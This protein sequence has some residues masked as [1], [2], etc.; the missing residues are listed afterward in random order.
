MIRHLTLLVLALLLSAC[1]DR[2]LPV[3]GAEALLYPELHSIKID[4]KRNGQKAT[5]NKVREVITDYFPAAPD[6]E[7]V[8]LY[9]PK[10]QSIA[11]KAQQQL[12]DA[13]VSPKQIKR[14]A[15]PSLGNDI[16]I[17]IK[18]YQLITEDCPTYQFG[19]SR[20]KSSCFIDTLRMKHI[21]APSRLAAKP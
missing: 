12:I 4:V 17:T 15:S 7:W 1:A 13:G 8:I 2:P 16:V 10:Q 6:T 5:Q 14:T 21:A 3:K 18:Q 20:Q 19:Q 9:R 11:K